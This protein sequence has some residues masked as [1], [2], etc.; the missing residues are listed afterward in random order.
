ME[1]VKESWSYAPPPPGGAVQ[2]DQA[3]LCMVK[4]NSI[5]GQLL[6]VLQEVHLRVGR[7]RPPKGTGTG[8]REA[9]CSRPPEQVKPNGVTPVGLVQLYDFGLHL[10]GLV[11][12]K[13]ELADVIWTTFV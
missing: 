9:S 4:V 7:R 6:D 10:F 13:T 5:H 1:N 2:S 3:N 11:W 8:C 12:S